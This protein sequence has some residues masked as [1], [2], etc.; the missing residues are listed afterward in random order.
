[1]MK[2]KT[3]Y[4]M[5]LVFWPAEVVK[6]MHADIRAA[7]ESAPFVVAVEASVYAVLCS[8]SNVIN[9]RMRIA[10]YVPRS[11]RDRLQIPHRNTRRV[12]VVPGGVRSCS[13]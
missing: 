12:V 6:E 4:Q 5:L 7:E 13:T 8:I 10:A 1:M 9:R 11:S 2:N 3:R